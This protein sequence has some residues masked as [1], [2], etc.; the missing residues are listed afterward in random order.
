[1]Q[2]DDASYTYQFQK[3][4]ILYNNLYE[5]TF[6]TTFLVPSSTAGQ[7]TI[8]IFTLEQTVCEVY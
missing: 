7:R 4:L 2:T 1:M 6:N 3:S 8:Q 5:G